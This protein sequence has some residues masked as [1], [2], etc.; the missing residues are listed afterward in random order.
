MQPVDQTHCGISPLAAR[1]MVDQSHSGV[2]PLLRHV[3]LR[4]VYKDNCHLLEA[5]NMVQH[6]YRFTSLF[7]FFFFVN[8]LCRGR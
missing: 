1:D 6:S 5:V 4:V 3:V 8:G 2:S 7:G